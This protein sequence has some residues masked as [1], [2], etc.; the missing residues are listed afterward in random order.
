MFSYAGAASA[1]EVRQST[2]IES[3]EKLQAAI[4]NVAEGESGVFQIEGFS[5][6]SPITIT[7]GR[8][9]TIYGAGQE[10][11]CL[12]ADT[13]ATWDKLNGIFEM[14]A[15]TTLTLQNL[16]V[17]GNGLA[18]CIYMWGG[19]TAS[20]LTLEAV[21]L[22]KGN[23]HGY[24]HGGAAICM[25]GNS[26]LTV[27]AGCSFT[28]NTSYTT[29]V[30]SG[31]IYVGPGSTA[32][33][34]GTADSVIKFD[35][36]TGHSGGAVYVFNSYLHAK[37]CIFQNNNAGQ[38]G[39]AIHC[40]G[41]AVLENCT[42]QS[43]TSDQYGGGVYVSA[44]ETVQ[45]K[46]ALLNTSITGNN[47]KAGGGGI[48]VAGQ[49]KVYLGAQ[50]EVTGNEISS[51]VRVPA[52]YRANN[53][54]ISALDAQVVACGNVKQV[55]ISTTNPFKRQVVVYSAS[56]AGIDNELNRD[57][58]PLTETYEIPHSAI[59]GTTATYK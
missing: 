32:S 21:T 50:T 42:L 26:T 53:L 35:G 46:M 17:D 51:T 39:G 5:L 10:A 59:D 6:T 27:E 16:T 55:G 54:Q 4:D 37:H 7:K 3:A 33:F 11:T 8:R 23:A 20:S 1:A 30:T 38:R 13:D 43:N 15:G 36:N 48:Y 45:G 56:N 2:G 19:D 58:I 47:S 22:Q 49:S 52:L 14:S 40:H 34:N 31:A 18:R 57:S 44:N 28:G 41:V 29:T 25:E 24:V 12:W 9:I